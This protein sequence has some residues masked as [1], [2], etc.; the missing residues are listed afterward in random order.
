[1]SGTPKTSS[2]RAWPPNGNVFRAANCLATPLTFARQQPMSTV[3]AETGVMTIVN[4][5]MAEIKTMAMAITMVE[6]EI[7][8]GV[9]TIVEMAMADMTMANMLMADIKTM[10]LKMDGL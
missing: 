6:M 2:L 1:M 7:I 5:A 3:D 8:I 4:M 9:L 10:D